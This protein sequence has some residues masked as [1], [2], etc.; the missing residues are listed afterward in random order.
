MEYNVWARGHTAARDIPCDILYTR[1]TETVAWCNRLFRQERSERT[2]WRNRLVPKQKGARSLRSGSLFPPLLHDGKD[3]IVCIV[4]FNRALLLNA[5]EWRRSSSFPDLQGGKLLVYLPD[6]DSQAYDGESEVASKGFF[7]VFN[8]PPCDT[9]VG[10]FF[11]PP[12]SKLEHNSYLLAYVPSSSVILA[13]E[14]IKSN[15]DGCIMWL[16]DAPV[17]MRERLAAGLNGQIPPVSGGRPR[18]QIPPPH[19]FF[20][21]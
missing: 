6:E 11:D 8:N 16:T 15:L 2:S 1:I 3:D 20:G 19:D 7:D 12:P 13:D 9:W 21:Q 14:G 5:P 17:S 10:Y 18:D 4:G